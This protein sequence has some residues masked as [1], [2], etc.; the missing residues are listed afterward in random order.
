MFD[1]LNAKNLAITTPDTSA[2][3]VWEFI[4]STVLARQEFVNS[5]Q[6][7]FPK[8]FPF[9]LTQVFLFVWD[10]SKQSLIQNSP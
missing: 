9:F 2:Q 8:Y 10:F 1:V 4:G 3:R 7:E 6:R 5:S